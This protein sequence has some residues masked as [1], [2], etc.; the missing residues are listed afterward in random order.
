[1]RLHRLMTLVLLGTA[2]CATPDR[3]FEI[4]AIN[5]HGEPVKC[6]VVVD[7][8]WDQAREAAIHTDGVI[9]LPLG[10]EEVFQ[11]TVKPYA[12]ADTV[13]TAET[14][15]RYKEATRFVGFDEPRVQ[16]MVVTRDPEID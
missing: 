8:N 15:A 16:L 11:L 2:A 14:R 5:T 1:M 12:D 7:R 9:K 4:R 10:E 3:E 6:L 13:P